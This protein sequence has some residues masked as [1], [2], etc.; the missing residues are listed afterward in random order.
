MLDSF[1]PNVTT[2]MYS[3]LRRLIPFLFVLLIYF[4]EVCLNNKKKKIEDTGGVTIV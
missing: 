4:S 2:N 3:S 1:H